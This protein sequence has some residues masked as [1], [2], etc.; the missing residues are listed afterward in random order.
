MLT[1]PDAFQS[2]LLPQRLDHRGCQDL[3]NHQTLLLSYMV[4]IILQQIEDHRGAW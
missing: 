2:L 1:R 4:V 3:A